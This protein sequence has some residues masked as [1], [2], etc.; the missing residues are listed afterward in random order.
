MTLS[1]PEMISIWIASGFVCITDHLFSDSACASVLL[2]SVSD[3]IEPVTILCTTQYGILMLLFEIL[4]N[5]VVENPGK[6]WK[7]VFDNLYEPNRKTLFQ[8][9]VLSLSSSSQYGDQ[10]ALST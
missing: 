6:P 9:Y 7:R 1:S 4:L 8:S 2:E 5:L 10:H 3:Q